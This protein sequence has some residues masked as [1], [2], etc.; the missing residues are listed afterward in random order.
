[1]IA[2]V[3]TQTFLGRGPLRAWFHAWLSTGNDVV[4]ESF[5]RFMVVRPVPAGDSHCSLAGSSGNL[6]V[7]DVPISKNKV[8]DRGQGSPRIVFQDRICDLYETSEE[9]M[10][11]L[12]CDGLHGGMALYSAPRRVGENACSVAGACFRG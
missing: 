9:I 1:M 6:S 2:G 10:V 3:T 12:S 4:K 7:P 8:F 11:D 5:A